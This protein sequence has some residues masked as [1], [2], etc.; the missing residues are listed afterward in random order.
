MDFPKHYIQAFFFSSIVSA[1]LNLRLDTNE[2][3]RRAQEL[4]SKGLSTYEIADELKVQPDTVVWLLLKGKER[5]AKP[6]P[7]DVYVDW[8]AVA[9]HTRRISLVGHTLADLA[10]EAVKKGEFEDPE[11]VV[12]LEGSGMALGL[13]AAEK[14]DKPFATVRPQRIGDKKVPGLISPSLTVI[15]GRK[16]LLVDAIIRAGETHSAAIQ[17]LR[18]ANGKP[19]ALI[20]LVNKSG[21]NMIDGVPLRA[22]IELLPVSG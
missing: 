12:A 6:A 21:K 5:T 2:L 3:I 13:A 1:E 9:E 4:K 16:I 15:E 14:L 22:L 11:V 7:F 8:H 20:V 18:E 10:S 17:T 19:V